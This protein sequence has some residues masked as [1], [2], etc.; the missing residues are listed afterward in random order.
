MKETQLRIDAPQAAKAS[1]SSDMVVQAPK[2]VVA[3]KKEGK[4][5]SRLI[6]WTI[7]GLLLAFSGW[8]GAT[9]ILFRTSV[10]AT[11]TAP[12]VAVRVPMQG[13][14]RGTPPSVGTTVT[15]GEMLFEVQ[16]A[17]PDHRPAERIRGECES[18]RRSAAALRAQI[19]EMDKI[20]ATLNA[21][22]E[23]YRTARIA[24]AE[25]LVAEQDAHVNETASR[26]KTAE[27]EQHLHKRLS[28]RGGSS[29]FDLARTEYALEGVRNQLE[30][31]RQ[32]AGR[33]QLQLAAARKGLF[34]GESDGGQERVASR[35]R[36]DEIEI[37]QAG[38]RARLGELEGKLDELNAQL[39]SEDE[40]LDSHQSLSIVAPISGVIW[41]STL[42]PGSEV[43][44]GSMAL[45]ILDPVRLTIEA[46]FNKADSERVCPGERVQAR[47]IGSSQILSGQVIRV[48]GS[49]KIDHEPVG[50]AAG[51]PM[52]ADT[53]LATIKLNEQPAGGNPANQYYVGQSAVVWMPR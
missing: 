32:K 49:G 40:Y 44:L 15:V 12:V 9:S 3:T 16:A 8:M 13:L 48:V 39:K 46:T 6:R 11:V 5:R 31:A 43:T 52:S 29:G 14:I 36:V 53:F 7:G 21:H 33:L 45:E 30:V 34:V 18:T 47:L 19:C 38:L 37:Q 41:S 42:V 25:K 24:Q 50:M 1:F 17:A 27:F 20:K 2:P 26:L 51:V 28:S 4:W 10:R 23:E 22:F 35:Q